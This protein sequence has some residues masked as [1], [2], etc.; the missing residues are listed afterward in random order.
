MSTWYTDKDNLEKPGKGEPWAPPVSVRI[1]PRMHKIMQAECDLRGEGISAVI[2]RHLVDASH[3]STEHLVLER[4]E[5]KIDV[6]TSLGPGSG[7]ALARD[8]QHHRGGWDLTFSAPKSISIVWA[9][10]SPEIRSQMEAAQEQASSSQVGQS[11]TDSGM[12]C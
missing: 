2:R 1:S 4:V 7:G 6:L 9:N 8:R 5:R 3:Q 12:Q 10:A 11:E